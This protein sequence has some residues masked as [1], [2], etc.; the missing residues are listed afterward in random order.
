VSAIVRC[1][2]GVLPNGLVITEKSNVIETVS[3]NGDGSIAGPATL[4]QNIPLMAMRH[5]GW[6]RARRMPM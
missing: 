6:S 5:L 2:V 4:V 1:Q 3:L